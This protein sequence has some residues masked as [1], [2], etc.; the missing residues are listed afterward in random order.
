MRRLFLSLA[1]LLI[2]AAGLAQESDPRGPL[3]EPSGAPAPRPDVSPRLTDPGISSAADCAAEIKTDPST[4]R[5]KAA[6]WY[7][8]GGGVEARLC[9]ASALEAMGAEATAAQLLTQ[10]AQNPNRAMDLDLRATTYEDAA[11]IWLDIGKPDLARDALLSANRL[12]DPSADRLVDLARAEAGTE[13]WAAARTALDQALGLDPRNAVALALRAA[14]LRHLGD[15]GAALADADQALSLSPDLPEALFEKGAALAVQNDDAGAA[16]AWM[17]LIE[18]HPDS[19]L[20]GPARR[21]LQRL[22]EAVPEPRPQ[23]PEEPG[24]LPRPAAQP[25]G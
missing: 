1:P 11:R 15:T 3:G 6:L 23:P 20:A 14:T 24:P 10:V 8:L 22:S 2:A 19:D 12:T 18:T 4:A 9:E 17:R 21:N 5:E 25:R 13:D 16:A 7:R